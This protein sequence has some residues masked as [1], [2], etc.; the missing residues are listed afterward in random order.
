[1][2]DKSPQSAIEVHGLSELP[3]SLNCRGSPPT[4]RAGRV[5]SAFT[6]RHPAR[7][8]LR[9]CW[10]VTRVVGRIVRIQTTVSAGTRRRIPSRL[11]LA[12]RAWYSWKRNPSLAVVRRSRRHGR[13]ADSRDG[14]LSF[15]RRVARELAA[16]LRAVFCADEPGKFVRL[17]ALPRTQRHGGRPAFS[18]AAAGTLES[19]RDAAR[20][21]CLSLAASST[22][23]CHDWSKGPILWPASTYTLTIDG[24]WPDAE[25]RPL[26]ESVRKSFRAV[27]AEA[28]RPD[29]SNWKIEPPAAGSRNPLVVRFPKPLDRAMLER[30]LRVCP[31]GTG[32]S[33]AACRMNS[34]VRSKSPTKRRAGAS[35]RETLGLPAVTLSWFPRSW[36]TGRGNSIRLPFEVDLNRPQ[37]ARP[38]SAVVQIEFTV[39]GR[40]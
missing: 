10:E 12:G 19:R 14:D 39:R 21:C 34:P 7:S 35:R 1:M 33:V 3:S 29:P 17:C 32:W 4:I 28:G 37:P 5:S 9:R 6:S 13:S 31:L 20:R 25:G 8:T 26:K 16:V 2:P 40:P 38:S 24:K 27:A 23:L 22:A 36:K 18:R 30:V 15:E 11:P